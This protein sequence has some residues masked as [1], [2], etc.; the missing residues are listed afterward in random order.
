M[1][2]LDGYAYSGHSV[3]MGKVRARWQDTAYVA[4]LFDTHLSTARRKY[5]TFIQNGIADGRRDELV[6]GGL[7]R[8]AGGWTA[9][10]ALRRV[11]AFQKGDE[12]I[13]GDGDFVQ[14]VLSEAREA[15]DR[16]YKLAAKGMGIDDIATK[17]AELLGIDPSLIWIKGK[18]AKGSRKNKITFYPSRLQVIFARSG[19]GKILE[20]ACYSCGFAT[21][22]ANKSNPNP[23]A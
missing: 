8:S 11:K 2:E 7:I 9:V 12:R 15:Y 5:R 19:G 18:Q 17:A 22:G 21:P 4:R 6:G 13:L 10:K 16:K 3:L 1:K 23:N 14:S 20:R